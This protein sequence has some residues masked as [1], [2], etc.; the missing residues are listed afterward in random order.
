MRILKSL[1]ACVFLCSLAFFA[2]SDV[3]RPQDESQKTPPD[4]LSFTADG[5]VLGFRKGG[6]VIASKDH[7]LRVEFM[8]AREISPEEKT[9]VSIP[10]K[11][12]RAVR[13]LGRVA[14]N[15]LWDGVNL[16]Y[17]S[18]G[19]G[20]VRSRFLIE[21]S[22]TKEADPIGRIGLRYN[23][24]AQVDGAG[25]LILSFGTGEMRESRPAAW[26]EIEGRRIPVEVA[27]RLR[28]EREVGFEIGDYDPRYPL[29][30]VLVVGWN[31][32]LGGPD[33]DYSWAIAL[34]SAG[35]I[36]V[37]GWSYFTWL[38]P[39]PG[40]EDVFVAKF[41]P[42]GAPQW[43]IVCGEEG[44]DESYA[45]ALDPSGNVYVT[46][47]SHAIW[48]FDGWED[49]FISKF[50]TYG[51]PEWKTWLG[52]AD[53][54]CGFGLAVDAS[55]NVYVTGRSDATWGSPIRP[56]SGQYDAF[57]TKLDASGARQWN[58]FLGGLSDDEGRGIAMDASGNVYVTGVSAATWGSPFRL[59]SGK[60]DG[61]VAKLD[62]DG[63][64]Q[65]NTFLGGFRD[66]FSFG[67]ALATS[68]D[69]YLSGWSEATWG[70]PVRPYA[71]YWDGY[72]AKLGPHGK[73]QWNTFLG[74]ADGDWGYGLAVDASANIYV[75]GYSQTTWGSPI[76]KYSGGGDAF[77]A[78]LDA[79]GDLLINAFL[80][81]AG[82]DA[83][84]GLARDATGN[85]YVTGSS[86]ATW[87]SPIRPH[88][89]DYDGFIAKIRSGY[90]LT[91]AS[92][93]H[94]TTNPAPGTY[95]YDEGSTA[96]V[97]AIADGECVFFNWT[98]DVPDGQETSATVSILM[99]APKSIQANFK[100]VGPPSNLT[101]VRLTNRSV[102]QI[103]YI[104]DL[105]W[106]VNP[107]NA[108]LSITTYRVYQMSGDSWVKL[109]DLSSDKLGYRVRN[110]PKEEQKFGVTSVT[111]GGVE[112][113]KTTVVK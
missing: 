74:G 75:T 76:L 37:T 95:F 15:E 63:N 89:G 16:V 87:G 82:V 85:I 3:V 53:Y 20:V 24:P 38:T 86:G 60:D 93:L 111:S 69:A 108:G 43:N 31:T 33:V 105:S 23:V 29:A 64:L 40:W 70:S 55:G 88:S 9:A 66:D 59:Y 52:V 50:D 91:V 45:I 54:N 12:P 48:G 51:N 14:Y 35:N 41:D 30:I 46:G 27:Y 11:N 36:Y 101:A 99:D 5:H 112:S 44:N 42:S 58:T 97:S 1:F 72:V 6:M 21:S 8:N 2:A 62:P 65:W 26:Q 103:E 25:D 73:L 110:V 17:E 18:D 57:I 10:E 90:N 28:G 13:P 107:A 68:G 80:G 94:G 7:A 102:T 113:A 100:P 56:Y 19:D 39:E 4:L 83:G 34:D 77:V 22:G 92:G 61:F 78:K 81:G 47:S 49:A 79:S 67:L 84:Y 104:V 71:G 98:G 109:A 106:D 96:S 32:F